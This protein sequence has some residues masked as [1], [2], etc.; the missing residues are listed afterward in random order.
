MQAMPSLRALSR[1][2]FCAAA[3]LFSGASA[4]AQLNVALCAAAGGPSTDCRFTDT[5]ARIFASGLFASVDILDAA[6]GTPTLQQFQAYDAVLVWSNTGFQ[7]SVLLGDTLADYVDGGGGVVV[8]VFANAI[9]SSTL[10]IQGRW[11]GAYEVIEDQTGATSSSAATLGLVHLP[12]HP[13]MAGV[14]TFDGGSSSF[15]PTVTTLTPGSLS[16]AEW[17]D[18]RILVAQ[19]ANPKRVDLGFYPPSN[20]CFSHF[21]NAATDGAVMLANSL[22]FAA[23]A[24]GGCSAP[25]VYC[26]G[27]TTTLGCAPSLVANGTPSA[28]ATSGFTLDCANLDGQR[29]GLVFYGVNGRESL[30]WALGSTSFLCVKLPLQRTPSQST[31]GTIGQCDG[32]I[33]LDFLAYMA[34]NP[35]AQGQPISAGQTYNAQVWFRDPPAPK[36]TNLSDGVEFTL[37]P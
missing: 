35:G 18:G 37:C 9:A 19:G 15:R 31:G 7:D 14:N 10:S 3:A 12:Q 2:L 26:T 11:Q 16:I 20:A 24:G 22:H 32:T 1:P 25:V 23:T 29:A 21:W 33:S 28:S 34:A 27:S 5:Q 6:A 8:A 30:S 17:S 36:T 13:I 4:H